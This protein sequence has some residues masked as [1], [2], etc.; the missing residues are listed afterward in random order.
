MNDERFERHLQ[1]QPMRRLPPA[2]REEI[3]AAAAAGVPTRPVRQPSPVESWWRSL[4]WPHP[5]AWAGVAAT[6][7]L[8]VGLN[9]LTPGP[10]SSVAVSGG[11]LAVFD[12]RST[13]AMQRLLEAE[14]HQRLEPSDR[15]PPKPTPRQR[16]RSGRVVPQRT[17]R[18]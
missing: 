2:W 5:V 8:I 4:L 14:P 6:W 11:T 10:T 13:L 18:V 16:P 3:L 7:L 1:D 17:F 12:F 9:H 15:E